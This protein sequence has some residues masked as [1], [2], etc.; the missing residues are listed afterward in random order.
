MKR[1]KTK[2]GKFPDIN[3]KKA[4]YTLAWFFVIYLELTLLIGMLI[5]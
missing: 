3:Y 5:T 2:K 4:V 1:I